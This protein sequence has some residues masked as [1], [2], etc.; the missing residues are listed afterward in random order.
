MCFYFWHVELVWYIVGV[1]N[2]CRLF[3]S[4]FFTQSSTIVF[5]VRSSTCMQWKRR[6]EC[7][8]PFFI[9]S[10][11]GVLYLFLHSNRQH[12]RN[13]RAKIYRWDQDNTLQYAL[14]LRFCWSNSCTWMLYIY[15]RVSPSKELDAW[16]VASNLSRCY[17]LANWDVGLS[18]SSL[19]NIILVWLKHSL[20][21]ILW[22]AFQVNKI[23]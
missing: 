4:F 5:C 7:R 11:H 8:T 13:E 10:L 6:A 16:L 15:D 14:Q 18:G 2:S 23:N 21:D 9:C 20:Y 1:K 3:V 12:S 19:R 17:H 22:K